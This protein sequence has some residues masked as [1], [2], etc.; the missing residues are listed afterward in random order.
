MTVRGADGSV[1]GVLQ[2]RLTLLSD[3][4]LLVAGS[5]V[6]L[7]HGVERLLAFLGVSHAPVARSRVAALLWPDVDD[8]RANGDLRSA[9][10]RLRRITGVLHEDNHRLSLAPQVAVDISEMAGLSRTLI[11]D[12][13]SPALGRLPELV[14][15]HSILPGWDEEWLV[16]ERERYRLSRLRALESSAEALLSCGRLSEA[17]D[18]ALA[19]V[20]TEPYRESAHR[21]SVRIHIAEGNHAE[22]L[23]AY[24]GYVSLIRDE[25]GIAPSPLMD[26][27][28]APFGATTELAGVVA[29]R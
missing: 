28:V 2:S 1:G 10:W 8:R 13:T 23:R 22:A 11:E 17:L 16:V 15:A 25:L 5:V 26:G 24:H 6:G 3:F 14:R 27:L 7:P 12:A 19:A 4:Q 20:D 29:R 18:A 9:L 21:L